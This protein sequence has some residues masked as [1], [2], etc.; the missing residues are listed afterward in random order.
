MPCLRRL[1]PDDPVGPF[2]VRMISFAPHRVGHLFTPYEAEWEGHIQEALL[3]FT[4][5]QL[6]SDIRCYFSPTR[7]ALFLP[8]RC[9]FISSLVFEQVDLWNLLFRLPFLQDQ[10]W[11]G[12]LM[13][14]PK[15]NKK[16]FDQIVGGVMR[17]LSKQVLYEDVL[18]I[19]LSFACSDSIDVD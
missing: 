14:Q 19:V 3:V 4:D 13:A 2:R 15:R 6:V 9:Y 12:A 17:K 8:D 7:I 18:G 10:P 16:R 11:V 1:S 5:V